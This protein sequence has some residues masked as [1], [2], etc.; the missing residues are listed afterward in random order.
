[1][2]FSKETKERLRKNPNVKDVYQSKIHYDEKFKEKALYEFEMGKHP[3][4]IFIDAGFVLEEISS[5]PDYPSKTINQWKYNSKNNIH[6]PKRK[7][8]KFLSK[9]HEF[10]LAK[11]ACLEEENKLLKKLRGIEN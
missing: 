9:E 2:K 6:N 7:K 5:N 10:L 1:M 8:M 11:I 4:Q 3:K